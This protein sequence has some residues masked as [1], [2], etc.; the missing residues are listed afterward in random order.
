MSSQLEVERAVLA[1]MVCSPR[2]APKVAALLDG[3]DFTR[4][5]HALVFETIAS[6]LEAGQ[7]VDEL[8]LS[9]ELR[10][11]GNL[12]DDVGVAVNALYAAASTLASMDHVEE[13][14]ALLREERVRRD[15]A[16]SVDAALAL[17]S[18]DSI[19]SRLEAVTFNARSLLQGDGVVSEMTGESLLKPLDSFLSAPTGITGH[20]YPLPSLRENY[21]KYERGRYTILGGY[22]GDGK[23]TYAF[24]WAEEL[25]R[26]GARACIYELEMTQL[27]VNR[28]LVLQGA[29]LTNRQAKGLDPLSLED[30]ARYDARKNV[31]AGWDLTVR[32]GPVTPAQ[33][34][35]EQARERYDVIIVDHIHKFERTKDG[36]YADMTRYSSQLHR[37]TRDLDCSVIALAQLKKPHDGTRPEP[38][39]AML[40]GAGAIEEDADEIMFVYRM[41]GL[42][43]RRRNESRLYIAKMRDGATDT[44]VPITLDTERVRFHETI[45]AP[46]GKSAAQR[47]AESEAV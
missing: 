21:G 46:T 42:N 13:Y 22:S 9:A 44:H 41:R 17:G 39:T 15:V 4:D 24:Q 10:R 6:M 40:R 5:E 43:Q 23:T 8:T 16:K 34:R 12:D 37:V 26:E 18:A 30:Q 14:A 35:A 38:T 25:C 47:R 29:G 11:E 28:L 33:I 7:R 45:D 19:V 2:L 36:E 1:C 31:V 20:N 32:C 27:G 3:F